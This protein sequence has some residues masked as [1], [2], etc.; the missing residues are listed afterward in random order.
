M[1]N[2]DKKSR[3]HPT[4]IRC[5]RK[6]NLSEIYAMSASERIE[7]LHGLWRRQLRYDLK[8]NGH[9]DLWEIIRGKHSVNYREEL[10][11]GTNKIEAVLQINIEQPNASDLSAL[12]S[13]IRTHY[14]KPSSDDHLPL[15]PR[16]DFLHYY[17]RVKNLRLGSDHLNLFDRLILNVY[18]VNRRMGRPRKTIVE[19]SETE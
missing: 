14:I 3:N 9:A 18:Q 5:K 16:K 10:N 6:Y 19:T 11:R 2:E 15:G 7:V 17:Y 8:E 4:S 12:I 13:I 1:A